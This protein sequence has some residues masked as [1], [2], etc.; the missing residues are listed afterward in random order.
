MTGPEPSAWLPSWF[1]SIP[2]ASVAWVTSTATASVGLELER[3]GAGAVEADLL[4]GVRD[5]GDP[6]G[7]LAVLVAAPRDLERDV[8]AEAVVHRARDQALTLDADGLARDHDR[9]ADPD[10]LARGIAVLGA[11]VDV[12]AA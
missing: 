6:A 8:R 11:D 1:S 5:A 12:E 3:G 2:G 10:E 4:L 7:E 9:V